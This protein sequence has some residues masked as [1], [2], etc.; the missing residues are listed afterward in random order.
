MNCIGSRCGDDSAF[1]IQPCFNLLCLDS[2]IT[3]YLVDSSSSRFS[4]L[5]HPLFCVTKQAEKEGYYGF[6][7]SFFCSRPVRPSQ[8]VFLRSSSLMFSKRSNINLDFHKLMRSNSAPHSPAGFSPTLHLHPSPPVYTPPLPSVHTS[9]SPHS[10]FSISSYFTF[11]LPSSPL[12]HTSP[13]P[14]FRLLHQSILHL[15]HQFIL[16][17]LRHYTFSIYS[18]FPIA[19]AGG[20]LPN[21]CGIKRPR[22]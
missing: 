6:H 7:T 15:L 13:S 22:V 10:T 14:P 1:S 3:E 2:G 12:V 20:S 17:L 21:L 19:P 16:H 9:P 8:D 5:N 11:A 4:C 18:H